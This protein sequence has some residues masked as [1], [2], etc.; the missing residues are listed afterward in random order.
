MAKSNSK[1]RRFVNGAFIK[2]VWVDDDD[3]SNELFNVGLKKDDFIAE[4]EKLEADER[5]FINLSMG[6][7]KENRDKF[8]LWEKED[9]PAQSRSRTSS[10]NT[11]S[12]TPPRET[13]VAEVDDTD[14]LPF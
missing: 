11:R 9:K 14:D 5:G 1:G 3:S 10:N 12:S 8:S 2:R 4:I 6:S 13:P 7:Q